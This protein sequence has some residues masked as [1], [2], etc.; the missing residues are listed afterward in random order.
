MSKSI[1]K[2]QKELQRLYGNLAESLVGY[3][4]HLDFRFFDDFNDEAFEFLMKNVKGVNMLDLNETEITDESIKFLTNLEYVK[5]IRAKQCP[6]LTDNCISDLNKLAA[7][8]FLHVKST[9]ITIDGLLQLNLL[10]NLKT[11]IFSAND[12]LKIGQKLIQLKLMHP[13]CE[14]IIDSKPYYFK[15]VDLFINFLKSKPFRYKLKIFDQM[16]SSEWSKTLSNVDGNEIEAELQGNF[17]LE[18][19]EW[20]EIKSAIEKPENEIVFRDL[21]NF[22][23]FLEF[24]FDIEGNILSTYILDKELL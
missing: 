20:I 18:N 22:L 14:M 11:L 12:V 7:L 4:D 10:T 21:I 8:S 6:N 19:V 15:A 9:E 1:L 5:E 17:N 2:K 3:F 16:N 23:E 24:P 13:K